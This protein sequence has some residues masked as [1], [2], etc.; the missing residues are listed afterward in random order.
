MGK[1]V[2]LGHAS[3]LL[4]SKNYKVVTD[5]YYDDPDLNWHFPRPIV[6]NDVFCSH[7]HDD[8]NAKEYVTIEPT[9]VEIDFEQVLVPHD[10]H[11]GAKRGMNVITMFDIDGYKVVHMGDTG[12]VPEEKVLEPFRECDVLLAPINGYYT[13]NP[14]EL[15]EI[16]EIIKPRI[17]IPMHYYMAELKHGFQDGNM[18]EEF[19]KLFPNH[20]YLENEILDLD[21][22]KNYQ[23]ALIFKKYRQN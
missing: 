18:I 7:N 13:I 22:Y 21:Q 2:Y 19:K 10:H 20:Q 6:A 17:V 1:I 11:G 15:K 16:C 9:D 4:E 8:H 23:G 14:K 3:F 12:C 5:P